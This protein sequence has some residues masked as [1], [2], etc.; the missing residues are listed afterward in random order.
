MAIR[1]L[2]DGLINRIAAG[3]VVERPASVVKEL[4]ENSLDAGATRI[5]VYL[6][7]GGIGRIRVTDNGCGI[8]FAEL[9]LAFAR[10]ATSKLARFEELEG[11]AT[12]GFRGEALASIAAVAQVRL[13]SQP[14]GGEGGE[15]IVGPDTPLSVRPV[16]RPQ[17]SEVEVADLF[18]R[19]PV[20]RKFLK[21]E[22]TEL[23]HALDGL[24]RLALARPELRLTLRHHQR[25][26]LD[27]SPQRGVVERLRAVKGDRLGPLLEFGEEIDGVGVAG[28]VALPGSDLP[29]AAASLLFVNGRPVHDRL[30]THAIRQ[31]HETLVMRHRT[32]FVILFVEVQPGEVDVNVH[33]AK[34]EVRFREPGRIH[35]VVASVVRDCLGSWGREAE[36]EAAGGGSA[37]GP[38][39]ATSHGG[40]S[41][42]AAEVQSDYPSERAGETTWS[43]RHPPGLQ[44]GAAPVAGSPVVARRPYGLTLEAWRGQAVGGAGEGVPSGGPEPPGPFASLFARQLTPLGQLHRTYLLAA[45]G[46]GL[47][48]VDQHAAHERILYHRLKAQH[49]RGS[50]EVQGLLFPE[51]VELDA[52]E[53]VL[54]E[55]H[56]DAFR[57]VGLDIDPF[58]D[59]TFTIRATPALMKGVDL[60]AYL[61]RALLELAR[62]EGEGRP[63]SAVAD[64]L[65]FTMACRSAV[66]AGDFLAPPE[67]EAL[68]ADLR[69]A[70]LPFTCEHGRP[71]LIRISTAEIE[72][73]FKRQV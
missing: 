67:I 9:P 15:V 63:P 70:P 2:S 69:D 52:A 64:Q 22:R 20:R 39:L 55:D 57:G 17:G 44:G 11:I 18:A 73:R 14:A 32:P 23:Q 12:L 35:N 4:V 24:T 65:L 43:P 1:V 31:A 16:A 25:C 13:A 66:R 40:Q 21:H 27:L 61:R 8:P 42:A 5:D 50:A 54:L 68:L 38:P 71:T 47:V 3:E 36:G 33:P 49:E 28:V 72:R 26:L 46:E 34:A 45:D 56:L 6:E 59:R 10:H 58:G 19:V 41:V 7:G 62:L 53:A 51:T 30:L 48:L 29:A 60:A 37:G